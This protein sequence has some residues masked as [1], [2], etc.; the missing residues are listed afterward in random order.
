MPHDQSAAS[1]SHAP[2]ATGTFS[3]IFIGANSCILEERF[4]H[5]CSTN[6]GA[7]ERRSVLSSVRRTIAATGQ[8][9]E[10]R[11]APRALHTEIV[12]DLLRRYRI[13]AGL[14]LEELAER[15]SLSV[16]AIGDIKRG[17][18]QRPHRETI[19]LLAD[20][21]DLSDEERD[22]FL[23]VSRQERALTPALASVMS[24]PSNLPAQ[25]TPLVGRADAVR[26]AS[27]LIRRDSV[28]LLTITG[29]GGVG[30]TRLAIAIADEM[31]TDMPDGVVFTPLVA[32]RDPALVPY[33]VT[34][35]LDVRERAGE[36][37]E[38]AIVGT[39]GQKRLLLVL[40]NFEH[41]PAAAPFVGAVL[42]A[43][44]RLAVLATSRNPLHVYGEHAFPLE[45][46]ALPP[47]RQSADI[48][49]L[50][51]IPAVDLFIQ[52]ADDPA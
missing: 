34:Q 17:V 7:T 39:I 41:L 24:A 15:A 36:S 20:A 33:A 18:K 43:C 10:D 4:V 25:V 35:A 52:R 6:H 13:A 51:R 9:R 5:Q 32:V 16:R 21:L 12:S 30:K 49:A 46:L 8:A 2:R 47:V 26:A 31:R 27:A 23:A 1:A 48:A 42:A 38:A 37:L 19:R 28:R 45:P 11:H 44:P 50:A 29:T 14:T 40:D 22:R 3:G